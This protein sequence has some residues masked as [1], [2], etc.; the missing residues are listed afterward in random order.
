[1]RYYLILFVSL[2][3]LYPIEPTIGPGG[4]KSSSKTR[5]QTVLSASTDDEQPTVSRSK[6]QESSQLP[7]INIFERGLLE[8]D[9][10]PASILANYQSY[11]STCTDVRH[12]SN[13]T[14]IFI[15]PWNNHGY[16]VAKIFA[17][18]FDYIS[19]VWFNVKRIGYKKYR[20]DG[21]HDIDSEWVKFLKEKNSD[22]RIVPRVAFEKWTSG[23]V[24][25]LFES[26][27]EKQQLALALKNFLIKYDELFDGYVFELLSQF[28]ASAKEILH[29]I[30]IDIAHH[31]HEIDNTARR[32]EIILAVPPL[33]EY[34]NRDDF[35]LLSEHLDG[36]HIM[37]Y[38]FS[39]RQ[40]GPVSPIIWI[41]EVMDRFPSSKT[42]TSVKIFLGIHLYGYRYDRIMPPPA[43]EQQQFQMK[44]ILGRDYIEFLKQYFPSAKIHFDER[45]H[46]HI[47]VV[48]ARSETN[49]NGKAQFLPNIILFYPS[50]KS[51]YDRLELA[52]K[53]NV[54]IAIWDGG[55]GFDYFFDLF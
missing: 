15:T 13:P 11:C 33:E 41:K 3:I 40:P 29:H 44:H 26:E 42:D 7:E 38:D 6:L 9:L 51:I 47:T 55:Q 45:A 4:H 27:G 50:L 32:K 54:G 43:K 1:M 46:E 53:L 5:D 22:I 39:G 25:A 28:H 35:N 34:L 37:T 49:I 48:H 20:I 31:I 21:T 36:F 17:Q 8:E 14:L 10:T 23:D 18:K 19:P 2:C 12:F 16:D 52:I 24:H 30:L